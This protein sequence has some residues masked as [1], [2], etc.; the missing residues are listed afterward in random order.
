MQCEPQKEHHWLQKFVGDWTYESECCMGPGEPTL[1]FRGRERARSIGGL[2]VLCE[3]EGEMP[4]G[5]RA[6]MLMTLGFDPQKK[7][8]TGT[9]VGSMMTTLWVY[10]GTLSSDETT[11]TLSADGP[12]FSGDGT[13][14][15]Y[16]DVIE[17][18]GDDHRV[19][20]SRTPDESGNW[21][22]FMTTHYRR[23]KA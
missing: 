19:L 2:W 11:L 10:D 7:R 16:Q 22:V 5:D 8:F 18:R 14:V 15:K 21:V 12:S 20:T 13:I 3:S 1:T 9:W 23:V 6:T 17:F 4:G